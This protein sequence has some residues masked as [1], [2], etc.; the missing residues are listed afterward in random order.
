MPHAALHFHL[1]GM[2]LARWQG[3]PARS[4]FEVSP[5]TRNAFLHGALGPDMGYF[6]GADPLISQ[7]AHHARTGALCRAL[8]AE[9]RSEVEAAF[10]WGWV[11]HVLGDVAIHPLVNEACGELLLGRRTPV[12]GASAG[13]AHLRVEIGLDA[14]FCARFPALRALRLGP[15]LGPAGVR[16]VARAYARTYGDAPAPAAFLHAHQQVASLAGALGALQRVSARAVP[17][18]RDPLGRLVRVGAGVP[19]K[20]I[21][22]L[23]PRGSHAHGLFTPVPPPAWM[24][25]EVR[26][27]AEGFADWFDSHYVSRLRF[28]R[29]HCLDTGEV[30]HGD[31]SAAAEALHA[32]VANRRAI[33]LAA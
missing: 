31:S 30:H 14:V 9:A 33:R 5:A 16:F 1:A 7:L 18:A 21:S 20:L 4:P 8:V 15:A 13:S 22:I 12:W 19:L 3:S 27:I 24:L 11:T 10:A 17:E 2:V 25:A 29:D 32:L 26:G 6:P 28:L 23:C